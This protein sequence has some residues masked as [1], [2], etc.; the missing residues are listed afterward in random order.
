[1]SSPPTVEMEAT[2]ARELLASLGRM[3][4][5][6]LLVQMVHLGGRG[7][8]ERTNPL[9]ELRMIQKLLM[10]CTLNLANKR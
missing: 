7:Q 8:K 3:V 1:M 2:E 10:M 5:L 6:V 9:W 4:L